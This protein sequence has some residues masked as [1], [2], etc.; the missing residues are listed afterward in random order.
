VVETVLDYGG[1]SVS[2]YAFTCAISFRFF[3]NSLCIDMVFAKTF[4][5]WS[6]QVGEFAS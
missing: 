6:W 3:G 2:T 5:L 1:H 4:S